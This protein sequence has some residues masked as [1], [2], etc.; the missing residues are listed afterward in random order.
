MTRQQE[1]IAAAL[2]EDFDISRTGAD[3]QLV[4]GQV[5]HVELQFSAPE[6][7]LVKFVTDTEGFKPT[8]GDTHTLFFGVENPT[9]KVAEAFAR[10]RIVEFDGFCGEPDCLQKVERREV[11]ALLGFNG[12]S[13]DRET[14][15]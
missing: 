2:D 14:D 5:Q 4:L 6:N 7:H 13:N 8:N 12:C 15:D 3:H 9:V 11:N 1:A 10:T